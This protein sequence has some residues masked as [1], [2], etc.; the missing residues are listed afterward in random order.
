MRTKLHRSLMVSGIVLVATVALAAAS[1]KSKPSFDAFGTHM[2]VLIDGADTHGASATIRLAVP[3]GVG[4]PAHIHT[5][6]DETFV[7]TNGHFRFWHGDQVVDAPA[8]T[9]V[10]MPRNEP[11]Q[12]LNV[13]ETSGELIM[14]VVPASLENFF[15]D[16]AKRHL[17]MPADQAA[18]IDLSAQYGVRYV[19]SLIPRPA[20]Q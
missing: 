6:E 9:V 19:P 8:G 3:A 2:T 10:F 4:P 12:F 16:V 15:L 18:I 20:A 13:G 1:E 7:V 5:K 11:H 17:A 14:T